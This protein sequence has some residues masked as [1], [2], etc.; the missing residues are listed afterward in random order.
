MTT[1]NESDDDDDDDDVRCTKQWVCN[2]RPLLDTTDTGQR[3][4]LEPL[5]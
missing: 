5:N 4:N 3:D 1:F 2:L